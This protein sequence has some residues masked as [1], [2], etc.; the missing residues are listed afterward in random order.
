MDQGRFT[1][2]FE[3]MFWKWLLWQ[4]VGYQ[5]AETGNKPDARDIVL[6]YLV[7]ESWLKNGGC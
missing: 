6:E 7:V 3:V 4:I 1:S 2:G 5:D